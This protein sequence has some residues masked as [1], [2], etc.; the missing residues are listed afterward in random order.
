MRILATLAV[1]LLLGSAASAEV[2]VLADGGRV[3]GELLNPKESPRKQYVIQPAEG[4]KITLDASQ[5][6]KVLRPRP[7]EI[8]YERIAP[9]YPDTAAGQWD[10]AQWCRE[11]KLT[12]QRRVHLR[13]VIE[14][15]P[16]HVAARHALGYSQVDGKWATQE[17]TMTSH[18]YVRKDGKWMLPQEVKIAEDKRKLET[19]QQEWCQKLKRWRGWL[20]TDRDQQA[21]DEIAAV[22]DPMAVKGLT[23]GLHDD[24]DSRARMLFV[25]ALAKIDVPDAARALAVASI[26]DSVEDV[27]LTCL[28]HLQTKRRPEVTSYYVGKLSSKKNTNE[29]INLA[30]VGLGRM[31]DPSAIGPL[32]EA[33]V[34]TH[35]FKVVKPGGDGAM[36]PT[37]GTGPGGRPGGAGMSMGGGP[38]FV[39]KTMQNQSVLDALVAMTGHNF[40]F[41]KQAWKFWYSSQKKAPDAIDARRDSK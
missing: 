12:A 24:R 23:M 6:Q 20:G 32:I 15:D 9:T 27:R 36:S 1:L 13:R 18:G 30:A 29:I 11:H 26:Y 28:D 16:N 19:A 34:T 35:K 33:L 37:F 8:E 31:K 3:T 5:V 21:R 40:N 38:K 10:L 4:A 2:F 41:D 7:E 25:A 22:N 17:E 14:L 39:Y